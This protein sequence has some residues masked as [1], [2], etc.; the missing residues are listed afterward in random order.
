MRV[1]EPGSRA[2]FL[3]AVAVLASAAA[4]A[5][6]LSAFM[7]LPA[8]LERG[9]VQ[10]QNA[11]AVVQARRFLSFDMLLAPMTSQDVQTVDIALYQFRLGWPPLWLGGLGALTLLRPGPH[12]PARLFWLLVDTVPV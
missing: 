5:A 10:F 1:D 9:A 6:A 12:R 7:W 8:T 11:F 4:V 3:R 2:A